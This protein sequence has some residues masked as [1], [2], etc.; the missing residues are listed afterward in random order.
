MSD[1][2]PHPDESDW[3]I[4]TSSP[5]RSICE[6]GYPAG[7]FLAFDPTGAYRLSKV[8]DFLDKLNAQMTDLFS[9]YQPFLECQPLLDRMESLVSKCESNDKGLVSSV[10]EIDRLTGWLRCYVDP[11]LCEGEAPRAMVGS[12]NSNTSW[13]GHDTRHPENSKC[14]V[15]G[16]CPVEASD[17]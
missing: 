8:F 17:E 10:S 9:K 2:Q 6:H 14:K 5:S 15:L 13:K 1:K 4:I 12:L 7:E 3:E 11:A 16:C